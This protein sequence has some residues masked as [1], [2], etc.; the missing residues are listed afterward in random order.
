MSCV[1]SPLNEVKFNEEQAIFFRQQ[2]WFYAASFLYDLFLYVNINY[3]NLLLDDMKYS[4]N[5]KS[6]CFK[7]IN[8]HFVVN[9]T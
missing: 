6:N 4:E 1:L 8:K 9:I 7:I 2:T 3:F 5:Y